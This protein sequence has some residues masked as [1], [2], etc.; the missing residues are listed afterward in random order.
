M[1][2]VSKHSVFA[3]LIE[4]HGS[5]IE[6]GR[7]IALQDEPL[8][9]YERAFINELFDSKCQKT[10]QITREERAADAREL[11]EATKV[12]RAYS[13]WNAYKQARATGMSKTAAI[14]H[15]ADDEKIDDSTVRSAI[16]RFRK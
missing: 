16:K 7:A 14:A 1:N 5:A 12:F 15:V 8:D 11:R 9:E 10:F 4:H 13:R 6:A 2:G 3:L